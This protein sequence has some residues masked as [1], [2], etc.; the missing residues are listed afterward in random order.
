MF[1]VNMEYLVNPEPQSD[2]LH[3][4][5]LQLKLHVH[6]K[7]NYLINFIKRHTNNL[8]NLKLPQSLGMKALITPNDV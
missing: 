4:H 1:A 6:G 5:A 3:S 2:T 8:L 7:L